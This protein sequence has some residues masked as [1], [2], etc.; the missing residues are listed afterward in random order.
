MASQRRQSVRLNARKFAMTREWA[1]Q[2]N[3]S[4]RTSAR[5]AGVVLLFRPQERLVLNSCPIRIIRT[6]R[7]S[8]LLLSTLLFGL[9]GCAARVG[10]KNL[11]HDR[12]D[13]SAA[14]TRSWKEQMLLN[15]VKLRYMDPPM[16]LDVQQVVQQ[17]TLEGSGSVFAP[18]W[19]GDTAIT[20][21]ASASGRWAESPTI[22]YTPVSGE[23]FTKSLLQP[24]SPADLFSLV[25][26]GWPI[27]AVFEIGVRSVNGLH[28]SSRT[29]LG[30]R[31]GDPDF[32]RVLSMLRE[33]QESDSFGIRVEE[34]KAGAGRIMVF[35]AH[36]ADDAMA[37]T[38]QKARELLHLSPSAEEFRLV[39]GAVP[40]DDKEIAMLTRSMMEILA[41][42][43]AGVEIPASDVDEGRVSKMGAP[44][45]SQGVGRR[46]LIRVHSSTSKPQAEEVFT[47][48]RYRNYWFWVDDRDLSS[49]RGLGFLMILFTL[50][51]SGPTATPPV[52]SISKP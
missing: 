25:Q 2:L 41:E 43:S 49:K 31:A 47:A 5:H 12:F 46:F 33:L 14:I 39:L 6:R 18:G 44:G 42:A 21:A 17:Y 13:Y 3:H 51:E 36:H 19:A 23:K 28:A 4:R 1:T 52:L 8:G 22:T 16:F 30:R 29:E 7:V 10:P 20:P 11:A 35:R 50:V 34:T 9:G 32:Y 45:V 27:D 38:S 15:M 26:S 40:Q 37:A 24:V 48:V